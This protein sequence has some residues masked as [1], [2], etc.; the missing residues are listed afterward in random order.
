[1]NLGT[2]YNT[3][4]FYGNAIT[5]FSVGTTNS[6]FG[7]KAESVQG[8]LVATVQDW[9]TN[10]SHTRFS[11]QE[12]TFQGSSEDRCAGVRPHLFRWVVLAASARSR[13]DNDVQTGC[14]TGPRQ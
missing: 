2:D 10:P 14:V 6:F 4:D 8:N 1:M 9:V 13:P 5:N 11:H 3:R 7:D 12:P